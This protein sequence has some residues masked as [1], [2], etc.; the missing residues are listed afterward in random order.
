M[1][2]WGTILEVG[3][4]K[5]PLTRWRLFSLL[6]SLAGMMIILGVGGPLEFSMNIGDLM[7]L[8]SGILFAIGAMK[9][10]ESPQISVFEQLFAFF[11]YGALVSLA[12]ALLPLAALGQ[13]P[14]LAEII[15]LAPLLVLLAAGFLIPVMWGIYW[16]SGQVDPGR[17]GILLQ[18]EA[19]VGITSAALF[20]GEPF[21]VRQTVGAILVVGAGLVEI[22][23]NRRAIAE[24]DG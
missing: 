3:L 23:G 5:R 19:V 21:G 2:A 10:R 18:I 1:P 9:V 8:L 15:S 14:S 12:L 20:A 17:L 7:A 24:G 11:L 6:L 22:F 4:M 13:P 16:G